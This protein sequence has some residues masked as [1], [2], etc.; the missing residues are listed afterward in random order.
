M[1]K[2]HTYE[3]TFSS[4]QNSLKRKKEAYDSYLANDKLLQRAK[5]YASGKVKDRLDEGLSEIREE[6]DKQI[7]EAGENDAVTIDGIRAEYAQYL[8][9]MESTALQLQKEREE[10]EKKRRQEEERNRIE[11]KKKAIRFFE[12]IWKTMSVL[13]GICAVYDL[14]TGAKMAFIVLLVIPYTYLLHRIHRNK[15]TSAGII[16]YLAAL[17]VIAVFALVA[18]NYDIDGSRIKLLMGAAILIPGLV[19]ARFRGRTGKNTNFVMKWGT[20]IVKGGIVLAALAGII[21]DIVYAYD[22]AEDEYRYVKRDMK[23]LSDYGSVHGFSRA[24]ED[25]RPLGAYKAC[26]LRMIQCKIGRWSV[27]K[28]AY[29][30][31]KDADKEDNWKD[32]Y[33]YFEDAL[34]WDSDGLNYEYVYKDADKRMK[35]AAYKAAEQDIADGIL[36]DQSWGGA[37]TWFERAG[38]YKDAQERWSQTA[39]LL[40]QQAKEELASKECEVDVKTTIAFNAMRYFNEISDYNDAQSR[41]LQFNELLYQLGMEQLMERE[42]S[43]AQNTFFFIPDD[44][45]DSVERNNE[46]A[47]LDDLS[48]GEYKEAQQRFGYL[49]VLKEEACYLWAEDCYEAENMEEARIYFELAG[50]YSDARERLAGLQEN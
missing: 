26:S 1:Q 46:A 45:K 20:R 25:I 44:Y 47:A 11:T 18:D 38:D 48:D 49:D 28:E 24:I 5:R 43:E 14:L 36:I 22:W 17:P 35:K 50:D 16:E 19:A 42:Y 2:A 8:D 23:E 29:K 32:A 6:L 7:A 33:G 40:Y 37:I 30:N 34:Y 27:A 41:G 4:K 39:D 15:G 3:R 12:L 13:V 9:G 31:G 21:F 10:V